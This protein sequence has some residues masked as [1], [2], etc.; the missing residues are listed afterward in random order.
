MVY[1]LEIAFLILK[2]FNQLIH[3]IIKNVCLQTLGQEILGLIEI[4]AF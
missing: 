1:C 3:Y 4:L 2:F